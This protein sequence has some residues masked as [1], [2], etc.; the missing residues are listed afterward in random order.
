MGEKLAATGSL[1]Y[2]VFIA[3]LNNTTCKVLKWNINIPSNNVNYLRF[4]GL[5]T[6][7]G[8]TKDR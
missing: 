2:I 6:T 3:F 8:G 7:S 5:L 1:V 4:R